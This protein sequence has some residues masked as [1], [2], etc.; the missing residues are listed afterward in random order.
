MR[1]YDRTE[2]D[3]QMNGAG[4]VRFRHLVEEQLLR[5][6]WRDQIEQAASFANPQ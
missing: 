5:K 3:R 2:R 1:N 4:H 6:K